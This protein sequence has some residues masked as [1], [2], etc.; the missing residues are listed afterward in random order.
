VEKTHSQALG[1]T[2]SCRL[3]TASS[4]FQDEEDQQINNHM[5]QKLAVTPTN[6]EMNN[7]KTCKQSFTQTRGAKKTSNKWVHD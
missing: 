7:P 1:G 6:R 2:V 5:F 3:F 4:W